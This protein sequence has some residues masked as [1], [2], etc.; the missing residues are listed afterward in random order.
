MLLIVAIAALWSA[1]WF[2]AAEVADRGL[3]Q[4]LAREA[5]GHRTWTCPGRRVAGYPFALTLL[6]DQPTFRGEIAG[7]LSSG[8]VEALQASAALVHPRTIAVRLQGPLNLRAEDDSFALVTSWSELAVVVPNPVGGSVDRSV[9]TTR[10]AVT[11]AVAGQGVFNAR[12]AHASGHAAP[13][14]EAPADQRFAL[15]AEGVSWPTVT[16]PGLEAPATVSTRGVLG[17]AALL[18]APTVGR[19]D[20]WRAA[21]GALHL[22][23]A[24]V[25]SGTFAGTAT[26]TLALDDAHR[27]AGRLETSL[28][29]FAPLARSLGIPLAGAQM[30]GL[31]ATLLTGGKA[32]P[33]GPDSLQLPLVLAEGRLA[34]GPF[35]TGLRLPP[36]Y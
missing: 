31:L 22:A 15:T 4:W 17:E 16:L 30:G 2:G 6:C 3:E 18:T 1:A 10:L 25:A 28:T 7:H 36:L 26:G 5:A 13:V 33:A 24:S 21:G 9:E 35:P 12:I 23:A 20:A 27:P 29:G 8:T 19:L 11:L 14:A 32:A 34:V